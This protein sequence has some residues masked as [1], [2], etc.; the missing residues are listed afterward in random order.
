MEERRAKPALMMP[1]SEEHALRQFEIE[2]LRQIT[3][4]LKRLN[5]KMDK[6]GEQI[7]GLDV[8]MARMESQGVDG[9]LA[10]V[11]A[12]LLRV[13]DRLAILE[14]DKSRRE[15]AMGMFEWLSK[16]GPWLLALA[17]ALLAL[18]GWEQ[19]A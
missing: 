14:A 4:N 5:D 7:N 3:D 16:F 17:L 2:A 9:D 13:K 18:A 12:M 6:Q 11:R 1:V 15:G 8:R 10:E 19:G